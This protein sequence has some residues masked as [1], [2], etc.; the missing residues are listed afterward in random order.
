MSCNAHEL[1][2]RP[3]PEPKA[4]VS[5]RTSA[6][7]ELARLKAFGLVAAVAL[8]MTATAGMAGCGSDGSTAAD[9]ASPSPAEDS[10]ASRPTRA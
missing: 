7:G 5:R 10:G 6:R 3:S 4:V 9:P 1:P 8:L 2:F